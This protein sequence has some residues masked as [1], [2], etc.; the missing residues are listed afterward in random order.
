M[1]LLVKNITKHYKTPVLQNISFEATK[2]VIGLL[3]ENGAGKTT[4]IEIIATLTKP[5]N[6]SI[7]YDNLLASEHLYELRQQ[8]GYLPQNFN[9]FPS[10]NVEECLA[11]SCRLKGISNKQQ[12]T[13]EINEKIE[14]VGLASQRKKKFSE[15]SG[16]MKQ[17]LGIAQALLGDPK[18]L[19]VDEPTV[20]L[21]PNER[22]AFR[23]L[24][25]NLGQERLIILSTHIIEDVAMTCEKILLL[26]QGNLNYYGTIFDFIKHAEGKVWCYEGESLLPEITEQG[27]VIASRTTAQGIHVRF[28]ANYKIASSQLVSPTLED[29]YIYANQKQVAL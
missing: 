15:L 20:G 14:F 11:Y 22:V 17:R 13:A 26:H 19:I 23:Q 28:I 10:L 8:I 6:G 2:G 16:G 25:N 21:D 9:F 29:A 7:L 18:L 27:S 12:R 1:N 5:T 24:L 4:L 3:G